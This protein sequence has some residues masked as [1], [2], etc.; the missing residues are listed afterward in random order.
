LEMSVRQG[1]DQG[2]PIVVQYAESESAQA[3]KAI[4]QQVAAKVSIMA[5]AS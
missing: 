1:G 4:A 5:L 3:L 2:I